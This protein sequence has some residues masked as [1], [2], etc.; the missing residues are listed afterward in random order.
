MRL[1]ASATSTRSGE[2]DE[3]D[4]EGGWRRRR[5]KIAVKTRDVVLKAATSMKVGSGIEGE[6]SGID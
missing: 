4:G 6:V 2:A 3:E 5:V 1:L